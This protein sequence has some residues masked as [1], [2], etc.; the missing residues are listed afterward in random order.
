[1]PQSQPAVIAGQVVIPVSV[2]SKKTSPAATQATGGTD[3]VTTLGEETTVAV[4]TIT[5]SSTASS[6]CL[7]IPLRNHSLSTEH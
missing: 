5:A 4:I 1:M 7:A 6:S 2:Q 3:V